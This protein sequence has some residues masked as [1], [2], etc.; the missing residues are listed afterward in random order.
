MIEADAPPEDYLNKFLADVMV[1]LGMIDTVGSG[2]KRLFTIQK[3]KYFPLPDYDFSD[4]KIKITIV[5][6]VVD[7]NYARK[8]A[9]VE[10]LSLQEI[11]LLDKVTKGK[12]LTKDEA[13]Q[14]KNKNLIEGRRPNYIIASSVAD[15]VG[16][17]SKYIKQ[18]GMDSDYYQQMIISYLTEFKEGTK[19]D[20]ENLLL[21]KLPDI[22]DIEQKKNKIK[23]LLQKLKGKGKI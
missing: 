7:I 21:D 9:E 12:E 16:E 5:G 22:L 8:L 3:D 6:K 11:I 1:N 17:K 19:S 18:K 15:V 20:F 23:N 13:K 4:K 2:I 14:L 10:N